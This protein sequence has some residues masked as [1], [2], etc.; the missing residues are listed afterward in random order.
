[1]EGKFSIRNI[2]GRARPVIPADRSVLPDVLSRYKD[3]ITTPENALSMIKSGD[4]I[5]LGTGCATPRTLA[6]ALENLDKVLDDVQI[7]H[8][9]VQGAIPMHAGALKTRFFHKAFFVD[10]DMREI[11]KQGKGDYI[12]ISIAH[13]P[14]LVKKG[15]FAV[16]AALIQ[17]TMPDK[18][19]FVSLGVSADVTHSF[20]QQARTVI[21]ELNPN[22][23]R[24]CGD[25]YLSMDKIDKAVVVDEPVLEYLYP[26]I[27]DAVA[28]HIARNVARLIDNGSTLQVGLGRIPNEMLR[29]IDGRRDLGIHSDV[30]C[31]SIVDLIERG[32]ITGQAKSIHRGQIV[33]SYCLGTQRLYDL[34]DNNP[35]F[36][37][38]GGVK[39][40]LDDR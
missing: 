32:I 3:K 10:N 35:L 20:V 24:T 22:M 19:G 40:R 6:L 4:R 37:F 38:L 5:F 14:H 33:T 30:I 1:M 26:P 25:T 39:Q 13:V 7:Y 17:V 11:I 18:H 31:D 16:D 27:D 36:A 34:I 29:Y 2:L 9:L 8:F 21:A 23:P 12:P 15:V 28:E